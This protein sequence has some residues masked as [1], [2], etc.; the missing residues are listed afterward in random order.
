MCINSFN[1]CNEDQQIL[2]TGVYL[3]ASIL[4]H[5]C[6]PNAVATFEGT[7]I[8]IRAVKEIVDL[9]WSK[10]SEKNFTHRYIFEI[11]NFQVFISYIDVL[12]TTKD[13]MED[14]KRAY[15]FTCQ[16]QKCLSPDPKEMLAACCPNKNC[17][18]AITSSDTQN[19]SACN[20]PINEE[21]W[22]KFEQVTNFT[23]LHLENMKDLACIL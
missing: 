7:T 3:G 22:M 16:C 11:T 21:F 4:D 10:V 9:N 18:N 8:N 6:E 17:D 23:D 13:R 20:E 14:L 1:I 15:Y 2:G 12:N 19:C 5:S